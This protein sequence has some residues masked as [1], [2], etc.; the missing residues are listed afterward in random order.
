L[1]LRKQIALNEESHHQ[2]FRDKY[3]E[4]KKI[5]DKQLYEKRT[6]ERIK[7]EKMQYLNDVQIPGKYQV[8]LAKYDV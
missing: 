3:E 8:D 2:K 6:L 7:K 1:E 5:R 4:G